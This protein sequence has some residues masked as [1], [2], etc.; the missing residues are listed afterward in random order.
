MDI[1]EFQQIFKKM[2]DDGFPPYQGISLGLSLIEIAIKSQRDTEHMA[3]AIEYSQKCW[4]TTLTRTTIGLL[5][6]RIMD[7]RANHNRP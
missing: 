3:C 5:N 7:Q 1:N 6:Q 2:L 4:G